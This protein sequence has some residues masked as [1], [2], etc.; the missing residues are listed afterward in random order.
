MDDDFVAAVEPQLAVRVPLLENLEHGGVLAQHGGRKGAKAVL[1]RDALQQA[2]QEGADPMALQVFAH[3][4]GHLRSTVVL[5]G[6][7]ADGDDLLVAALLGQADD[8]DVVAV[9]EAGHLLL[10]D[11][12]KELERRGHRLARYA[13][14][15]IILVKSPRA[16]E[17]VLRSVA[18]F[19]QRKLKLVV[20]AKKSRVGPTGQSSFLGFTFKG[21]GIRWTD[22]ALAEF[23]RRVRLLTGRSWG[24][25]MD[26]R[27]RKLAEYVRGW[28]GYYALSEY[29]RPIPELDHW[30]R[31]RVRCCYWKQWRWCRTRVRELLKLGTSKRTA[32]Q[33][34]LSRKSY[35][36]LSK[37][38]ATQTGMTN[39]WLAEQGLVSIQ[40]LW[41][42]FHYPHQSLAGQ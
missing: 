28:M 26:Y 2:E 24:V 11:L 35:W 40:T 29:Y 13:D 6:V 18:R 34:G 27:L 9:V 15:C 5:F 19:L 33:A 37:T 42:S 38:L 3:D 36:C 8:R 20:N 22:K 1:A 25:S 17:R 21:T 23:K 10:D 7:R 30:L 12:D 14:D 4:E 16:G 31:R 32:I 39:A 41:V